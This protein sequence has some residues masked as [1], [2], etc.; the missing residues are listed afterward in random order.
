MIVIYQFRC[1]K[2]NYKL[3]ANTASNCP[4]CD[5]CMRLEHIKGHLIQ[6]I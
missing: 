3:Y 5:E 2:C 4:I 6:N 1:A